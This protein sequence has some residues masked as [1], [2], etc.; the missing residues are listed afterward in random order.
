M[1]LRLESESL[2]WGLIYQHLHQIK[3]YASTPGEKGVSKGLTPTDSQVIDRYA[4][5]ILGHA[6]QAGDAL[7][8][9]LGMLSDEQLEKEAFGDVQNTPVPA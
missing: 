9:E 7:D 1:N 6:D 2:V 3:A 5:L 8:D 4:K